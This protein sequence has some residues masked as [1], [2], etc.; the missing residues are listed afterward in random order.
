MAAGTTPLS[1]QRRRRSALLT[2]RQRRRQRWFVGTALSAGHG[3][4]S[5]IE[6]GLARRR[7][8]QPAPARPAHLLPALCLHNL[9][10]RLLSRPGAPARVGDKRARAKY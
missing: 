6:S 2:H 4:L 10:A 1:T 7:Q 5:A 9:F 8:A 3:A